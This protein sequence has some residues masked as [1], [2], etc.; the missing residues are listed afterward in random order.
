M[1]MNV[2]CK[3]VGMNQG[4]LDLSISTTFE[5]KASHITRFARLF[6]C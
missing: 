6:G 1:I 5:F 4:A 3:D 2:C